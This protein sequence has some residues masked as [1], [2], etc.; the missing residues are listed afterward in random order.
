MLACTATCAALAGQRPPRAV[1]ISKKNSFS[2]NASPP[3][4]HVARHAARCSLMPAPCQTK[5]HSDFSDRL[6]CEPTLP[7]LWSEEIRT[8]CCEV[9]CRFQFRTVCMPFLNPRTRMAFSAFPRL[10]RLTLD[11]HGR[12]RHASDRIMLGGAAGGGIRG[13]PSRIL[14]Y[15]RTRVNQPCPP[16]GKH[17]KSIVFGIEHAANVTGP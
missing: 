7:S 14:V 8:R 17:S 10:P 4:H 3:L 16:K 15:P 11:G 9:W 12:L 6:A 13:R 1:A 2:A 5:T